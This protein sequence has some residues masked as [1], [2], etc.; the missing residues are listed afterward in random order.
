MSE[1]QKDIV[2]TLEPLNI[3]SRYPS[4]KQAVFASLTNERCEKIIE[5]T[6]GLY[7]WIKAKL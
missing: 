2:D 3:E 4:S 6:E 5:E 1:E 7:L